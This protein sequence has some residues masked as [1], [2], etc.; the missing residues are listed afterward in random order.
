MSSSN[1]PGTSAPQNGL[2]P[3]NPY[4]DL[5][6]NIALERQARTVLNERWLDLWSLYKTEPLK[7]RTD[8][9]WQSRL[10]DGRVFE[11]VETVASY[12][13][14]ALFFSENWVTLEA[15]EPE[16][17]ELLSLTAAHYRTCLNRS[18]LKREFRV[19]VRQLLLLGFSGMSVEWRSGKLEF[20]TLSSYDLYVESSRRHDDNSFVFRDIWLNYA[21]YLDYVDSG[22]IE[23]PDDLTEGELWERYKTT[24]VDKT[25]SIRNSDTG[26]TWNDCLRLTEYWCPVEHK[27]FRFVNDHCVS[28]EPAKV[29][30][31][32]VVNLYELPDNAYGLGLLDSSIGL[33]VENNCIMNRR[34][35]NM[36]VSVDNMW[37]FVDDGVTNPEEIKSEPG[38]V[39][40]VARPDVLTPL[41]PP[42][43]NFQIT[44]QE[45]AF[46]DGKI[47]RNTGTGALI[48]S[49]AY[50]SGE[51][52]TATEVQ[53]VKD[54]GGTKLTDIYEH[55]E[56]V[57]VLPL[58]TYC[59]ELLRKHAKK[60]VVKMASAR[61]GVYDYYQ[62]VPEDF[63]HNYSVVVSASQSI[64]NR[65]R[66]IRRLQE[67]I[68]L[69]GSVPQF[70]EL[71]DFSNLYQDLLTKFGFDDPER[72]RKQAEEAPQATPSGGGSVVEALV[73]GAAEATGG[74]AQLQDAL[75]SMAAG[76]K[77]PELLQGLNTGSPTSGTEQPN[78]GEAAQMELA[79]NQPQAPLM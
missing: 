74:G 49:G 33:I 8:E 42:P 72:Y 16:L 55:I 9:G 28:E 25:T 7:L 78:P 64:I 36:A 14:D 58:L 4:C 66:N 30:P 56:N 1:T 29:C 11:I 65:D 75:T 62:L 10:N 54:A 77:L 12:L 63:K 43:N 15:Q 41:Y 39:L 40:T 73:G 48:S 59:L 20:Q 31:W 5:V 57:F 70:Q 21:A 60:S 18:N 37:L 34:L 38:K 44:Y 79:L 50:R 61:P 47:E 26:E 27:L 3:E 69:V 76:G 67:F 6:S 32:F 13:R 2:P 19:F 45:A 22:L 23:P 17:G 35:D 51:R 71:V 68:A 52:V 24:T 46:I 53:S